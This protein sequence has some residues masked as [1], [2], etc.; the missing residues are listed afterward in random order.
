MSY[1]KQNFKDGQTLKAEHLNHMEDG[2]VNLE[3]AVV[4]LEEA[5]SGMSGGNNFASKVRTYFTMSETM[6]SSSVE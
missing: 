3:N 2:I 6:F 1:T 5:V 4:A